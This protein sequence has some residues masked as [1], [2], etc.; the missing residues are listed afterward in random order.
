VSSLTVADRHK[1]PPITLRLPEGD[2]V[3]L[4][5]Q[6]AATGRPV[7]AILADAVAAYR[8]SARTPTALDQRVSRSS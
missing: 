4:Y 5:E 1:H 3:W 2:R 7:R 8:R 6:E